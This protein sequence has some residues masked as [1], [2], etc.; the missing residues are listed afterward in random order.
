MKRTLALFALGPVF[1]C[2]TQQVFGQSLGNA[3]TVA[4]T[5][6]DPSGATIPKA[7]VS[8]VNRITNYHQTS[9]ADSNGAFRL[10]NVPANPYHLEVTSAGFAT[11]EQDVDVRG[12]VPIDLKIKLSLAGEK[13]SASP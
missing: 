5:V 6:T 1:L 13:Q 10:T 9:I 12:T 4:G 2:L 7:A 8:I 11:Y 3:G